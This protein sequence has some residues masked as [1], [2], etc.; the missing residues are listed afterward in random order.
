ML[1]FGLSLIF[2]LWLKHF[3]DS[4]EIAYESLNGR[5]YGLIKDGQFRVAAR[6]LN[7][8]LYKQTP[9]ASDRINKM[10]TINLANAYKKL[11]DVEKAQEVIAKIDW[12][13]ATDDFQI[14]VAA[15][16]GNIERVVELMPRVARADV[17]EK[18]DFR[19]WPVFDGVREEESVREK[20][21]EI[22]DEPIIDPTDEEDRGDQ[23]STGAVNELDT[24]TIH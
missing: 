4:R 22:Y 10:M 23:E 16:Q 5:T 21:Q 8:A 13:A 19:E 11:K 7:L 18:S 1:E 12:S 20:F 3:K 15:V 17:I 9:G 24:P 6:L 2:V 14:C